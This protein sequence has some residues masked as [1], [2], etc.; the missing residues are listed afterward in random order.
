[1][2]QGL[3]YQPDA[4]AVRV[5]PDESSERTAGEAWSDVLAG[6]PERPESLDDSVWRWLLVHDDP[7]EAWR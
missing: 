1:M 5:R 7:E 3:V 2:G 6:R 4:W